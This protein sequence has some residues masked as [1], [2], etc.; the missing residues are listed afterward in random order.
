M[1]GLIICLNVLLTLF[2]LLAVNYKGC[3]L[4]YYWCSNYAEKLTEEWIFITNS[5][6]CFVGI[7]LYVFCSCITWNSLE[8]NAIHK[9]LKDNEQDKAYKHKIAWGIVFAIFCYAI[10]VSAIITIP[11]YQKKAEFNAYNIKSKELKQNRQKVNKSLSFCGIQLGDSFERCLSV[12]RTKMNDIKLMSR[13]GTKFVPNN[14]D[15][16]IDDI[17]LD[18][19]NYSVGIDNTNY[20]RI[21]DSIITA[22]ASWDSQNVDIYIYFNKGV[23]IAIKVTKFEDPIP[24]YIKKYGRPE[25]FIPKLNYNE[26]LTSKIENNQFLYKGNDYLPL[27]WTFKN[28]IIFIKEG[29]FTQNILYLNRN[30][31]KIYAEYEQSNM[32]RI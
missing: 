17:D 6:S 14:T 8:D 3:V 4:F 30:C 9:S 22:Q 16:R 24:M 20:S 10:C 26:T 1:Y 29:T 28:S 18:N 32:Q 19:T 7:F 11:Y 21:V 27:R 12:A 2:P 13:K 23:N 5:C 31:E 15:Y 25:D